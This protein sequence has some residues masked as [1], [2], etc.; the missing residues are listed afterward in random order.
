MINV[1]AIPNKD[2]DQQR[3]MV[4]VLALIWLVVLVSVVSVGFW[5]FPNL[6]LRWVFLIGIS[7]FI[8]GSNLTLNSLGYVRFA[9]WLL[10]IM[11]WLLI[12]VSCYSSGGIMAPS[13]LSQ[14]SVILTAGFL[15]GWRGGF[16]I[17][18]LTIGADFWLAYQETTGNLPKPTVLH[19]PISRW[20]SAIIPFGTIL[21]LQYYATNHLRTSLVALQ[22]EVAKREEAEKLKNET[23]YSLHERIKE[24]KTLYEVSHI[25]QRE[26]ISLEQLFNKIA[27]VI[28]GG[29][30]YPEITAACVAVNGTNYATVNYKPS[31]SYIN[32]DAKTNNGTL[33]SIEVVY[34]TP[35]PESDEGPFLNEE[36]SLINMLVEMLKVNLEQRER[37]SELKEYK[38]ALDIA[39]IV[40]ISKVDGTFSFVNENFCKT[41]KYSLDELLGKQHSLLWSTNHTQE[42]FDEMR[43]AMQNGKPYR[44][45]FCT[46]AKDGTVYW[47]D[48]TIVPFLDENGAVYQYL[49]ISH[50]IT[51]R[52]EAEEK[53]R[54]SERLMKKITSQ[55]PGNTYMFEI[56]EDGQSTIL[57]S[58]RGT[59]TFNH[60]FDAQELINNPEKLREVLHD[61]DKKKF[62]D[63]MKAAYRLHTPLSFQYRI[64]V[65]GTIRW[66]WMQAIPGID[67]KGKVIWYGS[68]S[69]I[70]PLIDY[71]ASIEQI[72][73][74]ISHVIRRPISKMIGVTRLIIDDDLSANEIKEVSQKLYLITEE[75]DKFIIE[76]NEVYQEKRRAP[77]I[78][79][80]LGS[81]I[82]KRSSLFQ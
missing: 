71:I 37:R 59:D 4:Y 10:P 81:L 2:T 41:S 30:Q 69:D 35:M 67:N 55:V 46:N 5:Y 78:D 20:I 19:D 65:G 54:H 56:E 7:V 21:A 44:G 61:D 49:S 31:K 72:I 38:Y 32:A 24:L 29:W 63:A 58:N 15:L 12:T 13:V 1:L 64:I 57:F 28:P 11:L 16:A 34:L 3:F 70:T 75:L 66:R 53:I 43:T 68:T 22:R 14:M 17:G 50:D 39:S 80:D 73:F 6:W 8:S 18:L 47:V 51:E 23:L 82:D 25:L 62:N 36:R 33:I 77:E 74:D 26:D 76:L 40:S 48:T 42:Y 52:K 60:L 79:I 27:Q 9:S 45:Q